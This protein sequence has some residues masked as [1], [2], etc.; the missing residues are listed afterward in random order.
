[1]VF[2]LIINNSFYVSKLDP[3]MFM[4]SETL[5]GGFLK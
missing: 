5:Y 4:V 1:M 3:H 2:E